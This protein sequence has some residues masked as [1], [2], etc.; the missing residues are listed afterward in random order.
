[1]DFI[2]KQRKK[3]GES[4]GLSLLGSIS[5]FSIWSSVNP[6]FFTIKAFAT[7]EKEKDIKFGMNV[8]LVLN[9]VLSAALYIAYPKKGTVPAMVTAATG[10]FLW[11][12]YERMLK[13]TNGA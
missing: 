2:K 10:I 5:A 3:N 9:L 12:S 6:S 7:P 1:L 13:K 8:G 11:V 4:I